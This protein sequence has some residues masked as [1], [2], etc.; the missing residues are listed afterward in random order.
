MMSSPGIGRQH[1]DNC[2]DMPSVPVI[3]T[4]G[5]VFVVK[6]SRGESSSSR[7]FINT[8]MR[9]AITAATRRPRP[10]SAKIS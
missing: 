1:A 5:A 3:T 2:T 10:M 9:F 7:P 8:S 4:G 6:L